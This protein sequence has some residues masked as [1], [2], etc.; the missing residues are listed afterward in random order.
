LDPYPSYPG[1]LRSR[2]AGDT[3]HGPF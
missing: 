1:R 2:L 3:R